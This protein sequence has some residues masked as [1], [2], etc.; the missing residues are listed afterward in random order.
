MSYK[1]PATTVC[2]MLI[3]FGV[4]Y[5]GSTTTK[6]RSVAMTQG[7]TLG[8]YPSVASWLPLTADNAWHYKCINLGDQ[9]RAAFV[10]SDGIQLHLNPPG[11]LRHSLKL[12]W[13]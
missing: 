2:N 11:V 10:A 1:I 9:V 4:Y 6:W 5:Y 7:T 8:N 3:A 13:E 12:G